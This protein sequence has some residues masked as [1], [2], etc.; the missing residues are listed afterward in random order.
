MAKKVFESH[1]LSELIYEFSD[2]GRE[3]HQD[4]LYQVCQELTPDRSFEDV[5]PDFFHWYYDN[6]MRHQD[7]KPHIVRYIQETYSVEQ[8]Y[9]FS[10][11][12]LWC[13][14]CSRHSHYK[15]VPYKPANPVPESKSV[16]DCAC[17]CRHVY[18][19]FKSNNLAK[20]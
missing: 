4:M 20:D 5:I 14:C 7:L 1:E 2:Q 16:C 18:R 15:T 11:S 9:N 19:L 17:P 13:R 10:F 8:V 12:M 6:S 3:E